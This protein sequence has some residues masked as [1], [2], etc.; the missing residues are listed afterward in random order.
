[1]TWATTTCQPR[2]NA[3]PFASLK[4]NGPASLADATGPEKKR[5]GNQ[6]N[7]VGIRNSPS[8]ALWNSSLVQGS[9]AT[10]SKRFSAAKE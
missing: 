5:F 4:P 9:L 10:K 2:A 3:P 1:M 7:P 8:L 6:A